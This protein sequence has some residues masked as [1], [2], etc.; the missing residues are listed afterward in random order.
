MT[1]AFAQY[2]LQVKT[3]D[4]TD[5]TADHNEEV[6]LQHGWE[7]RIVAAQHASMLQTMRK[8]D[9]DLKFCYHETKEG[10]WVWIMEKTATTVIFATVPDNGVRRTWPISEFKNALV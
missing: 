9:P 10:E 5:T 4:F 1:E 3:M 8:G 6:E 2:L 7:N